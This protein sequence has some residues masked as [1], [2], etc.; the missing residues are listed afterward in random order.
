[1]SSR[2]AREDYERRKAKLEKTLR[3]IEE[4]VKKVT[5]QTREY[6]AE[7]KEKPEEKKEVITQEEID[8]IIGVGEEEEETPEQTELKNLI[9]ETTST[10]ADLDTEIDNIIADWDNLQARSDSLTASL[11]ADIKN[12]YRIKKERAEEQGRRTLRAIKQLGYR[13]GSYRYS[14]AFTGVIDAQERATQREVNRLDAEMNSLILEAQQASIENDYK[15]LSQKMDLYEER[16][17][18][19]IQRLKE[20]N[21]RLIAKNEEIEKENEKIEK[22]RTVI[23]LYDKGIVDPLDI[24]SVMI[25]AGWDIEPNEI[26]DILGLIPEGEA[27]KLWKPSN[28]EKGKLEQEFGENWMNITTRQ[29]QLDFLYNKA[30]AGELERS[31]AQIGKVV[32]ITGKTPD[33][34]RE[35]DDTTFWGYLY[36]KIDKPREFRFSYDDMGKLIKEGLNIQE[37][38]QLQADLNKY[39]LTPEVLEGSGLTEKQINVLT[40]ILETSSGNLYDTL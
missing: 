4:Q 15:L 23:S 13:T 3:D 31:D 33:E 36:G 10:I 14:A 7:R 16:R 25:D 40:D 24:L 32:G 27:D 8:E 19:K 9:E 37:I 30:V 35:M 5:E 6:I 1:L 18:E 34:V 20:L 12:Q 28:Q 29:Q 21:E 2:E 11:I 22:R 26:E 17:K 38:N 39:G